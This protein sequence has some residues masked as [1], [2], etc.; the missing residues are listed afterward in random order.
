MYVRSS[1]SVNKERCA[2]GAKAAPA[3]A[4]HVCQLPGCATAINRRH[5]MCATHWFEVP[6][7]IRT[8]VFRSLA[9]WLNGDDAVR[10]YLIARLSAI[11][12]VAKLHGIDVTTQEAE[13]Q[14]ILDHAELR[15]SKG[16]E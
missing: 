9:G 7:E 12:A 5:L 11:V 8:E 1:R 15:R 16:L 3:V 10:P 14:R 4:V 2:G 6:V 13:K